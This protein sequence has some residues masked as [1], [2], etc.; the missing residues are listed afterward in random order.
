[1]STKTFTYKKYR[2]IHIQ[3][4][5]CIVRMEE[6]AKYC[7]ELQSRFLVSDITLC[8]ATLKVGKLFSEDVSN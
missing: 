2:S 7:H 4:N 8:G 3:Y 5:T 1:M 6:C